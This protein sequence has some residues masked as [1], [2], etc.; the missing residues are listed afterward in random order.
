MASKTDAGPDEIVAEIEETRERLAH[1]VDA[2]IDRTNPKN[3]A[4]RNL[5][6]V[7]AQFVDENGSPRFE[8]IL[9]VVGGIVGFAGLVLIIRKAVS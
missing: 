5:E 1:T 8:T 6:S 4:R 2:L 9:P 3:I 7:K